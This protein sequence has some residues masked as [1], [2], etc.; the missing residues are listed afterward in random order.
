MYSTKKIRTYLNRT[1]IFCNI[2]NNYNITHFKTANKIDL[3]WW[4]FNNN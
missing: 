2:T 4:S 1:R 3:L